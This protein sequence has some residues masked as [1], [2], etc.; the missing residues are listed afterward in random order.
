MRSL[1]LVCSVSMMGCFAATWEADGGTGGTAGGTGGTAGGQ[2]TAGGLGSSGGSGGSGGRGTSGGG[3][4]G[5][6][7][8]RGGGSGGGSAGVCMGAPACTEALD[9]QLGQS[10][11]S[12]NGGTTRACCEPCPVVDAVCAPGYV[13]VPAGIEPLTGCGQA[14]CVPD[15][16]VQCPENYSPVCSTSGQTYGN[17]CGLMRAQA[18]LLHLGECVPGEGLDCGQSGN[19]CGTS[20]ALYCRDACPQCDAWI[21]R[22]T[23]VGV[24]VWDGDCPAGAPPPP[25]VC[26]D[27]SPPR[28]SCVS[29]ACQYSCP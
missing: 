14:S 10:F 2:A 5:T 17:L 20:G 7:G 8:G 12:K 3:H 11:C 22:C 1:L 13:M 9:C 27:G 6:S 16:G 29:H 21:L 25:A 28:A 15:T 23:K 4:G 18:T 24:C 19:T 26:P